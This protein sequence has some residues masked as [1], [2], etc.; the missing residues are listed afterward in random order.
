MPSTHAEPL[1]DP[2]TIDIDRLADLLMRL[3][4]EQREA[5][6]LRLNPEAMKQLEE[7]ADDIAAGN[8]VPIDEW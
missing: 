6:E 2:R 1:Y 4:P 3:T 5:L 7:S 8:T